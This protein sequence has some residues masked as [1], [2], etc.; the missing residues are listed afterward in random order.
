MGEK[1]A[2]INPSGEGGDSRLE[3]PCCLRGI[4]SNCNEQMINEDQIHLA[5][6]AINFLQKRG[7]SLYQQFMKVNHKKIL[8]L[9][10][11]I[12]SDESN[13]RGYSLE[14]KRMMAGTFAAGML[15]ISTLSDE[16]QSGIRQA[17]QKQL[18]FE[19]KVIE[20]AVYL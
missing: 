9:E 4:T 11:Q 17:S 13:F 18:V 14:R 15:Y 8:E 16:E 12:Y 7:S 20:S 19:K 6:T 5:L 10:E 1:V 3:R 2:Q